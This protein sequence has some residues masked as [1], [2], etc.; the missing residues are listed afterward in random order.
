MTESQLLEKR[1]SELEEAVR[2]LKMHVQN[3]RQDVRFHDEAVT[4]LFE[5]TDTFRPST[6]QARQSWPVGAEQ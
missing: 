2:L 4:T 3:T 5:R 6:S 1:V